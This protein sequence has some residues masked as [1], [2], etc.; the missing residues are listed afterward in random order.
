MS[1]FLSH[2]SFVLSRPFALSF[3]PLLYR[4][5]I[6]LH[7]LSAAFYALFTFCCPLSCLPSRLSSFLAV[8]PVLSLLGSVRPLLCLPVCRLCGGPALPSRTL[9]SQ[10][11]GPESR[12]PGPGSPCPGAGVAARH[13]NPAM[14]NP[15]GA[16]VR[17][18]SSCHAGPD[19]GRGATAR[20][21]G[22]VCRLP[23]HRTPIPSHSICRLPSHS[24]PSGLVLSGH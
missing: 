5:P 6:R 20:D 10:V 15:G 7:F 14:I 13:S 22:G 3:S 12:V 16:G 11:P 24:I 8:R 23:S 4:P 21:G 1:R 9:V 2:I 19:G 17:V 18:H